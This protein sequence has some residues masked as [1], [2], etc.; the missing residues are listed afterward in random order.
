MTLREK[1]GIC[2]CEETNRKNLASVQAISQAKHHA[3]S[4]SEIILG[5]DRSA[6]IKECRPQEI[7]AHACCDRSCNRTFD[8]ASDR[9]RKPFFPSMKETDVADRHGPVHQSRAK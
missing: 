7:C 1:G 4:Q 8:I 6:G 9:I 3:C 2:F 5:L